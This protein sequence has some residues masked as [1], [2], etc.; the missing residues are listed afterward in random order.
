MLLGVGTWLWLRIDLTQQL[1][2]EDGV[3]GATSAEGA[4]ASCHTA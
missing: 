4:A 1:F 3:P 2:T